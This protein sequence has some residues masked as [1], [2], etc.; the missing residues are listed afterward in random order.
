MDSIIIKGLKLFG[1][2]GVH[3]YEKEN[4]QCFELDIKLR[5]DLSRPCGSDN[6]EDTVSYSDVIKKVSQVFISEKFNLIEKAAQKVAD[7]ILEKFSA[8]SECEILLKKPEAPISADFQYV[9]VEIRRK[10]DG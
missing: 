9:A 10:R 6:V 7:A 8:V 1:Y 4:G 3:D 2:H 5:L